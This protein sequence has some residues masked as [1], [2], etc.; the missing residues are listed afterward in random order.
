M[1]SNTLLKSIMPRYVTYYIFLIY[2]YIIHVREKKL[3][4]LLI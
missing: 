2:V 4:T 3:I 1:D